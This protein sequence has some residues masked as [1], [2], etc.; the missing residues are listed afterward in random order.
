ME[1]KWVEMLKIKHFWDKTHR[2]YRYQLSGTGTTMQWAIGTGTGQ[3]GTGTTP[4]SNLVF[5]YFAL[6]SPLFIH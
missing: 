2:G 5:A 4:S 6:L 1:E 3:R